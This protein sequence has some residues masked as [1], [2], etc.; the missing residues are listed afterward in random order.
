E[1]TPEKIERDLMAIVP[2]TDWVIFPHLMIA[3]GRAI[4]KARNPVCAECVVE[5]LCPSSSIK[6]GVMPGS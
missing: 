3:H 4:C 1:K 2:K 6:T 5:K